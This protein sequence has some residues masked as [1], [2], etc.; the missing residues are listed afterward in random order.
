[1]QST[2]GVGMTNIA[3]AGAGYVGLAN[4]VMLARHHSV[5]LVDVVQSKVDLINQGVSPI[6]D[7]EIEAALAGGGLDLRATL[8]GASAYAGAEIVFI[9]TPTNYDEHTQAFDTSSVEEAYRAVRAVN[10][11]C[12]VVIK[13]TV[14]IGY[15]AGLCAGTGDETIVF[16]PEFLREGRALYDCLHPSRIIVGYACDQARR[17]AEAVAN[18][19]AEG[20]LDPDVAAITMHATE[21]EAVKLFAN[22]Y[23]ALRV[24][25]FNELD[26]FASVHGL[27]AG[28]IIEGVCLDP[29]VGDFYNNPSFGYGG[30]CL[31][32][33]TKQLLANYHD[34]PQNLIRAIVESNQTRISYIADRLLADN[35]S[36]V[37]IYRLVMKSG[38][39]N[40]RQSSIQRV[41]GE[42]RARGANVLIY[43]P[44]LDGAE[45]DGCEV[46]RDFG[47]FVDRCDVI[48]ANRMAD[49]LRC[50]SGKVFT[51]D[52]FARD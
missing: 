18:L 3:V 31:P 24:S 38:S 19:L 23:L 16:S 47:S 12:T 1:M 7:A 8:D 33:D 48:A 27:D 25:F 14:P 5:R 40:F 17:R 43:E 46:E 52:L 36:T 37:G 44:M 42:L 41:I 11:G 29:R 39:D 13:S 20:A 30:Y 28:E 6:A 10:A 34:V 35:P 50:V 45:F 32:K 2:I 49:E 21:A 15:T 51:R 4:A 9:A 22:T 26:T